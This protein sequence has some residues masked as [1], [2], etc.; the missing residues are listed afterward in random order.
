DDCFRE[1]L[2]PGAAQA[3]LVLE[4]EGISFSNIMNAGK[5]IIS[6]S[7]QEGFGYL[8]I[9][10]L[11]WRKPLFAR[12]LDIVDDFKN[13]FSTEFSHFYKSV[14]IPLREKLRKQLKLEYNKKISE[15]EIFLDKKII[16]NLQHQKNQILDENSIDFLYLSPLMQKYFLRELKDKG[17]LTETRKMNEGKLKKMENM[18]S[19]DTVPFENSIIKK[20]SLQNHAEEIKKIIYSLE[21]GFRVPEFSNKNVNYNI[22]SYFADFTS[23]SLLYNPI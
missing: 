3:G 10:S 21:N 4:P 9:N 19:T 17:L 13:I 16:S 11:Q 6:S 7:V 8:F 1:N 2:I 18:L 12:N 15:L 5:M 14:D 22:I 23:I 20:F